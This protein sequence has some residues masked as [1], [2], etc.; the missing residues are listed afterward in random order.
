MAESISIKRNVAASY[1]GQ[2][3]AV[4]VSVIMAPVYLSYMGTEA[5]GLIGFFTVLTGWFQLLDMGLTP[6]VV[7]ETALRRGGEISAGELH[8][9][10]RGLAIVFGV[11]S[12]TAATAILLLSHQ[13]ATRWRKVG[14][15]PIIDVEIS[16]GIMG[17]LGPLRW[18]GGLYR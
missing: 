12:T 14:H 10:I 6:T 16:I 4:L 7:R 18:V 3:Y 2:I 15:L 13:I 17:A 9:F 1:V 11:I 5:Y 8:V